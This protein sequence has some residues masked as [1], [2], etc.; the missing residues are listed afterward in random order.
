[1][2]RKIVIGFAAAA[3]GSAAFLPA[4]AVAQGELPPF[5]AVTIIRSMGMDPLGRPVRRGS[6]YVLRA[7]DAYGQEVTVT[8]DAREGRVLSVRPVMA[9]A[10]PYG[11]PP[12]AYPPAP[13]GNPPYAPRYAP[14]P[15]LDDD[16]EFDVEYQP[17][18]PGAPPPVVYAPR[19][20]YSVP[21]P[22]G[23]VPT[24]KVPTPKSAP[25]AKTAANP[26]SKTVEA[27][28]PENV[29]SELTTGSAGEATKQPEASAAPAI[30]PVQG[31]N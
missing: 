20:S 1:V 30:P 26:A 2:I 16:D 17:I 15:G 3:L 28:L 19:A 22:P 14:P 23:R 10:A 21:R 9:A 6:A 25:A 13:Y 12:A 29:A 7:L 11:P 24:A 8:L 18:P 27:T 5:E 4:P 31:L